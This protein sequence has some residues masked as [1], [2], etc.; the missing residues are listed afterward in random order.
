MISCVQKHYSAIVVG[1]ILFF[2]ANNSGCTL[3][4]FAR[5]DVQLMGHLVCRAIVVI[6]LGVHVVKSGCLY[7]NGPVTVL[8]PA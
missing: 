5:V 3:H 6:H 8:K 1:A 7:L 2:F 4:K